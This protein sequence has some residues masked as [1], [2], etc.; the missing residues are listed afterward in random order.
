MDR[1]PTAMAAAGS[2]RVVIATSVGTAIESY[3]LLLYG[4]LAT[5]FAPLFFPHSDPTAA[6]LN[7]F[8]IFA[9]G[10]AARPL[11]G[12]V[13][14]HI[15]DRL[16]RRTALAA[17]I[18]IMA[19][20]GLAIGLLPTY[21]SI[22]VW[23]PLLLLL[24]RLSQGFSAGGEFVGANLL[25]LEHATAGRAGRWVSANL[26]A[27]QVGSAF[28]ASSSLLLTR[29]LSEAQLASWGWRLP[30]FAAVPLGLVGL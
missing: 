19:G 13:F 7:T 21:H 12:I 28:A 4:F 26:V 22:G 14:G 24:C 29:T 15:G 18:L 11:G 23:A 27:V 20:A 10:F 3:D 9:V 8:A 25:L 17:S 30:F 5:V 1:P 2:R 6:L 16:G